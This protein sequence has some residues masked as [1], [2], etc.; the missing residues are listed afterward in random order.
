MYV[1]TELE[2][3]GPR[4]SEL[5]PNFH[6]FVSFYKNSKAIVEFQIKLLLLTYSVSFVWR[7]NKG[8]QK[9]SPL[10]QYMSVPSLSKY[11]QTLLGLK[12]WL[13]DRSNIW[14]RAP[15]TKPLKDNLSIFT[16]K[17]IPHREQTKQHYVMS[18]LSHSSQH[19][20]VRHTSV[21]GGPVKMPSLSCDHRS[22]QLCM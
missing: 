15:F 5:A 16:C 7:L 13:C 1:Y 10:C 6:L 21:Y 9:S 17:V 8:P 3:Y 19:H 22:P 4:H 11:F 2:S 14:Q 12:S 18:V 20:C